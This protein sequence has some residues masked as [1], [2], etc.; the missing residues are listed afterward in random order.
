MQNGR[1]LDSQCDGRNA[2]RQPSVTALTLDI[3]EELV[4]R[5]AE[6]AAELSYAGRT[7]RGLA[8]RSRDL[9]RRGFV[10]AFER[11]TLDR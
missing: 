7:A 2:D 11:P 3:T 5:I 1:G 6:R 10:P 9:Y 4:E 8:D